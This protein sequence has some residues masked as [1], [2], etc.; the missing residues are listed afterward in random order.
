MEESWEALFRTLALLRKVAI[1]VGE[2]LGF[3]YPD[4]MVRRALAYMQ[5]VKE[6]ASL[7]PV[8]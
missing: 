2:S 6:Q 5:K 7:L 4:D 8:R 1:E 3:A